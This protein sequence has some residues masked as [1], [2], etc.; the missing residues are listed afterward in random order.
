M[1]P[2]YSAS[3][4]FTGMRQRSRSS[5]IRHV[6]NGAIEKFSSR[7]LPPAFAMPSFT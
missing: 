5:P 4:P 2:M 1:P 7:F 6:T 3:M